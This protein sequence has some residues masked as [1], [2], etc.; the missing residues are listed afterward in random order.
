M[1]SFV[2]ICAQIAGPVAPATSERFST[3][4]GDEKRGEPLP[5]A[6]DCRF[7][8]ATRP[9]RNDVLM[10]EALNE[11]LS[12][13]YV[14]EREL[15][16][17]GMSTVFV[18][19]DIRHDR[20]VALKVL[21]KE[22]A[23]ALGAERFLAEIRTTAVLQHPHIL[24]LYDSGEANGLLFYVMPFIGESITLR[25]RLDRE[26][27]LPVEDV[28]E[29]VKAVASALHF[30]HENGIVHRDIKPANILLH[31]G[32]PLV[33]DFGIAVAVSEAGGERLTGTGLSI[34][35][36]QYMSPEQILGEHDVEPRSDLFVLAAMAYEMLIGEHPFR[37]SSGQAV[38]TRMITE[39]PR[40]PTD[41]RAAVPRHMGDAILRGLANLPADR[42]KTVLDFARALDQPGSVSVSAPATT[43][44]PTRESSPSWFR[45]V[46]YAGWPLALLTFVAL[47]ADGPLGERAAPE[48]VRFDVSATSGFSFGEFTPEPY[49]AVSP[50]GSAIA[51]VASTPETEGQL[52]IRRMSDESPRPIE[53]TAGVQFPFWSP[54]AAHIA[55]VS[56]ER[57]YRI[58]A[59]GGPPQ[60]LAS[61]AL[62][63]GSWGADDLILY[64]AAEGLK[65]VDATGGQP[66]TLALP[67][68]EGATSHRS[69]EFLPDGERFLFTQTSADPDLQGVYL[70]SLSGGTPR[71]VLREPTNVS[72][73]ASGHLFFAQGG[74]L[75]VQNFDLGDGELTG[76]PVE[77]VPGANILRGTIF[78]APFS[79]GAGTLVYRTESRPITQVQMVDRQGRPLLDLGA[80]GFHITP[81][82]SPDGDRVVMSQQE[83]TDGSSNLWE[84]D[85]ERG[86]P[87]RL[88]AGRG[89]DSHPVW[90]RDGRRLLFG[91]TRS[92]QFEIYEH[93]F[94]TGNDS[95]VFGDRAFRAVPHSWGVGDTI[96]ITI[97]DGGGPEG[98][99]WF[100]PLDGGDRR[101][102]RTTSYDES[103]GTFSPNGEHIAYGSDASGRWDVY[104]QALP[105]GSET[106]IS[107]GGG[108]SP[109]WR[110]DGRELYYLELDEG[111]KSS[112]A[113]SGFVMAA[114][115]DAAGEVGTPVRLFQVR[116]PIFAYYEFRMLSANRDG[117]RFVL[118]KVIEEN[119]APL[120]VLRG[121][122]ALLTG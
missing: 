119:E 3:L 97:E 77:V 7:P 57:L 30:A 116:L 110:S 78:Y 100:V 59:E 51:L 20:L 13:R 66:P 71:R 10:L 62:R 109:Q 118:P 80:P 67:M 63:G 22:L 28:V 42:F 84:V 74:S 91:S 88:S 120:R 98:D 35:T 121:W 33:A 38:L 55:Y 40:H 105:S 95:I 58:P 87:R 23:Q 82:M 94:T 101:P 15:G 12:G 4:W 48:P 1:Y 89:L 37:A 75:M 46:A 18:A 61:D 32:Q 103:Q 117:S 113:V 19:R 54:D 76:D 49:P 2:T 52:F 9:H 64:S 92:G 111:T 5:E 34:G 72:V 60:E 14:V 17:G 68:P 79:A 24:P 115:V 114:P 44:A 90:S 27:Q 112:L 102:F 25:H 21:S 65:L 31:A 107:P 29:I 73:M 41:L 8:L 11:A 106:I 81:S 50:D 85:I 53:R 99:I 39:T 86:V 45:Y 69:P 104:V 36:P 47:L 43:H 108:T 96:A 93:D 70:A 122:E 6:L 16:A 83:A 56:G 26:R